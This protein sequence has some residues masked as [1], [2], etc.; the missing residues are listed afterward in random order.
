[1]FPTS[2]RPKRP[3]GGRPC[4]GRLFGLGPNSMALSYFLDHDQDVPHQNKSEVNSFLSLFYQ[5]GSPFF[6]TPVELVL[7]AECMS[8]KISNDY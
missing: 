3:K 2:L 4:F 6:G 7:L 5:P 8:W 1:M